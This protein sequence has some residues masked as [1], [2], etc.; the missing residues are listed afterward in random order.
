MA[1]DHDHPHEHDHRQGHNQPHRHPAR[2][3][4]DHTITQGRAM[5]SAVRELLIDKGI[6]S[7]EEVRRQVEEMDNRTPL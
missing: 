2:P 6:L 1:H 5:E 4:Q 7:A 3:D